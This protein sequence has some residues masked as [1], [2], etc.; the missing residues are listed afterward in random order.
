VKALPFCKTSSSTWS[1]LFQTRLGHKSAPPHAQYMTNLWWK[2]IRLKKLIV[3][4]PIGT[5]EHGTL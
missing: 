1:P 3:V 2:L 4:D 5:G